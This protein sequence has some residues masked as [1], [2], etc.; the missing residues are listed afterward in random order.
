MHSHGDTD[1]ILT[2]AHPSSLERTTLVALAATG[3]R[4]RSEKKRMLAWSE[5]MGLGRRESVR[6]ENDGAAAVTA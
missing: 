5:A 1:L 6:E 3:R 2:S 4:A